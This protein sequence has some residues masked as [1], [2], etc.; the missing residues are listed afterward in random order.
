VK[1]TD[2]GGRKKSFTQ[3]KRGKRDG[4]L[5]K[6]SVLSEGGSGGKNNPKKGT[7]ERPRLGHPEQGG[8]GRK[9]YTTVG[10]TNKRRTP[11]TLT[12]GL[13]P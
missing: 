8:G 13:G 6:N 7:A 2:K 3:D 11:P 1:S 5:E 9:S 12:G 10:E 4:V